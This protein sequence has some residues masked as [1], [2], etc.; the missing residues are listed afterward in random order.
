[1][2]EKEINQQI[3]QEYSKFNSATYEG[4]LPKDL[5]NIF[6]KALLGLSPNTH[7]MTVKTIQSIVTKKVGDLKFI[8]VGTIINTILEAPLSTIAEDFNAALKTLQSIENVRIDFNL[9]VKD[10]QERLNEKR[11][12]L[13]NLAGLN[14]GTFKMA[15]A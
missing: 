7:K 5:I 11:M 15:K 8:E 2:T 14:N 13:I 10:A 12:N 9:K 6:K 1:M 3:E 4:E